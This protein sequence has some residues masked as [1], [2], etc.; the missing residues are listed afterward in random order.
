MGA[1]GGLTIDSCGSPLA[2][3]ALVRGYHS[4]FRR[5]LVE[6]PV[7]RGPVV[8][9]LVWQAK[10]EISFMRANLMARGLPPNVIATI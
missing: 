9:G 7:A 5:G 3:A 2:Q 6:T 1:P 4:P 10:P 8:P